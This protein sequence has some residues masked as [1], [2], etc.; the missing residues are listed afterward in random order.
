MAKGAVK[1]TLIDT[2]CSNIRRDITMRVLLPGQRINVK[3]L[4]VRYGTSQTPVKLALNRLISENIVENFPRQGMAV[5]T[6]SIRE[7]EETF[8]MRLMLYLYYTNKI[9][10]TVSYNKDMREELR[11]NVREHTELIESLTPESPVDDFIKNYHYDNMFHKIYLKCSGCKKILEI[12]DYLTP[13]LYSNYIFH[14]QSKEKDLA[15][16]N[17]HS[18]ILDAIES[19]DEEKL[20]QMLELHMFR[21]KTAV[22]LILK[23]NEIDIDEGI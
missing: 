18:M 1:A 19:E 21:A 16:V 6:V 9:I 8:D 15:G 20:K 4:S 23:V 13:F 3:E 5:R 10:T 12:N 22:G 7:I 17:E 11:N 2:V 14:R